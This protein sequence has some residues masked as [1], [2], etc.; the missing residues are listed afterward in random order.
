MS[1]AKFEIKKFDGTN[2]FGMWQC[3]NFD[4]LTQQDLNITL[5][6]KLGDMVDKDLT[7]L[8][9]QACGSI[10]L[11]FVKYQKYFIMNETLA[12]EL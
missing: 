3:E 11:C 2:N 4:V 1:N 9:C 12:K 10:R 5:E 7:K 6:D 8:N